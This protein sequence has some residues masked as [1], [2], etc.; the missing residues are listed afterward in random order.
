MKKA[1]LVPMIK[2]GVTKLKSGPTNFEYL[3]EVK[4]KKPGNS[5]PHDRSTFQLLIGSNSGN[6]VKSVKLSIQQ[7]VNKQSFT[8][9]YHPKI[10]NEV[11]KFSMISSD[12][13][14]I[15]LEQEIQLENTI[16]LARSSTGGSK[17]F[18]D[19]LWE[20]V[21][22]QQ[23]FKICEQQEQKYQVGEPSFKTPVTKTHLKF[24]LSSP[25]QNLM[26]DI[27]EIQNLKQN[28]TQDTNC[29]HTCHDKSCC[30]HLCCKIGV[31]PKVKGAKKSKSLIEK[32]PVVQKKIKKRLVM[33]NITRTSVWSDLDELDEIVTPIK[34]D[35]S[36]PTAIV[37]K[38]AL[39]LPN[40]TNNISTPIRNPF[41]CDDD[42][43]F[44]NELD[45]YL[46]DGNEL[47]D[48]IQFE[49]PNITRNS[50][51]LTRNSTHDSL[52]GSEICLLP[53]EVVNIG[54]SSSSSGLGSRSQEDELESEKV[55]LNDDDQMALKSILE[56]F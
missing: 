30:R 50:S 39:E 16:K 48:L 47:D 25:D 40:S 33:R 44:D 21:D 52:V 28:S 43:T 49:D 22:E 6:L 41:G 12:Y 31:K 19:N 4:L 9:K 3:V 7:L 20:N 35:K 37:D 26:L 46:D 51:K 10:S 24:P 1:E 53:S 38:L 14:G 17:Y 42:I 23:L 5:N 36:R 32:S 54:R 34:I 45:T 18:E 55:E 8:V 13:C 11:L 29:K 15:D 2:M 56:G 27:P